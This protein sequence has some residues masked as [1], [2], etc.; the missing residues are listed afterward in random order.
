MGTPGRGFDMS[1]KRHLRV[2]GLITF[3]LDEAD[4]MLSRGF[5]GQI[6]DILQTLPPNTQVCLCSATMAPESLDLTTKAMRDAVRILVK[7]D[8]LTLEGT[9]QFYVAIEKEDWKID[10]LRD[11]HK[12]HHPGQHLLQHEAQGGLPRGPDREARLHHIDNACGA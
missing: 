5:K 3:V 10:T 4:V 6:Y 8:E 12:T 9:R 1:G 7:K 2:D 11:L